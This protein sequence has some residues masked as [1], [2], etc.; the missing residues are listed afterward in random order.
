MSISKNKIDI[1]A[2]GAHPDDAEIGAGGLLM[3][4][5]TKGYRIGI[6][7]ITDGAAG[8]FGDA[9]QRKKE[10]E[11]AALVLNVDI[12][13]FLGMRDLDIPIGKTTDL[14]EEL[15]IETRPTLILTHSPDDWHP[16]HRCVW[17]VVDTA[18]AY[19]NRIHR[20]GEARIERPRILQFSTDLLRAHKP[21]LLADISDFAEAKQKAL[22]CYASQREILKNVLEFNAL[23]GASI[24]AL[25]AEP[26]F[27][28]EPL[29]LTSSLE[30][31]KKA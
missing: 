19:A 22:S 9:S 18:W 30:L 10:A 8:A 21:S 4:A 7:C 20:H 13:R 31:V 23:W 14:L 5:K 6:V 27:S 24:G 29:V 15:F 28:L 17:Q 25:Y 16:D 12:L 11:D 2:I 26:F 1:L 3:A